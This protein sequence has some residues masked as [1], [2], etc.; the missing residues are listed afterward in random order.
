MPPLA[1]APVGVIVL[2]GGDVGGAPALLILGEPQIRGRPPFTAPPVGVV[3]LV[4][5]I[6][7]D[8]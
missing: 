6:E 8:F 3:V 5:G 4:G 2:V 1:V 7:G